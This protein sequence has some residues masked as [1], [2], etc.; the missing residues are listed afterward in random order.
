MRLRGDRDATDMLTGTCVARVLLVTMGVGKQCRRARRAY[1]L[2]WRM[3][4]VPTG[5]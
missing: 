3:S 5:T 1:W 2:P 4:T